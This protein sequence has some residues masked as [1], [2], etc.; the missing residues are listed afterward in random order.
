MSGVKLVRGFTE[1]KKSKDG[2]R[3]STPTGTSLAPPEQDD[4]LQKAMKRRSAPASTPAESA[5]VV[6]KKEEPDESE[7]IKG[8]LTRQLSNLIE[9]VENPEAEEEAIRKREEKEI[10]DE[11]N[12]QLGETQGR[13]I[14]HVVLVTH[15]IGQMLGL[16]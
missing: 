14:E 12:A 5:Q 10:R 9:G 8:R 2:K 11:Y 1:S 4:K 13:E 6:V 3:P 7:S 16:K 15:G